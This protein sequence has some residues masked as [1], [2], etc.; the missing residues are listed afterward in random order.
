MKPYL[1]GAVTKGTISRDGKLVEKDVCI[2]LYKFS[3][4]F[5]C[6]FAYKYSLLCIHGLINLYAPNTAIHS[7]KICFS[8]K[9][10]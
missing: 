5:L 3:E 4:I 9:K 7:A 2:E 1:C 6:E 10:A 8:L